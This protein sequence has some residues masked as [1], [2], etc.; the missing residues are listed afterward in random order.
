MY[1][2]Y[3][4]PGSLLLTAAL[5]SACSNMVVTRPA[6]VDPSYEPV[7]LSYA[8]KEG[9]VYTEVIGNPYGEQSAQVEQIITRSLMEAQFSGRQLDFVTQRP[10]D[11]RSPFKVVVL[12]NPAP[13]ADAARICEKSDQP[14]TAGSAGEVSVMVALCN[15]DTRVSSIRGF[16]NTS[17]TPDN[18][19]IAQLIRQVAAEI[20]SPRSIQRRGDGSDFDS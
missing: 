14:Q 1:K 12:F 13:N 4:V 8:S 6:Y 2:K 10:A 11:Y 7:L 5:L 9:P 17:A 18:P 20:F 19:A 15:S 3:L 16:A